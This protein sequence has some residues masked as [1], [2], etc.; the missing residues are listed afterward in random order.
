VTFRPLIGITVGPDRIRTGFVSVRSDY[1]KA[2][3]AAGGMPLLLAPMS[4]K[5][6]GPLLERLDGIV[7]SGGEDVDPEWYG[8]A[9]HPTVTEVTPERDHFEIALAREALSRDRPLLAICRGQQVLNVATG[10]TLIQD[11]PSIVSGA[12]DHDPKR[13]RWELAHHVRVLPGSRLRRILGEDE[14]AVNS[15]HHQVVQ[16]LGAGLVASAWSIGDELVEGVEAPDRRFVVGVQ[17]HPESLWDRRPS[18]QS[19]FE[20]LVSA[21]ADGRE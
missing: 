4:P 8:Q 3:E 16:D 11:V 5:D 1:V 21:S 17:W 6:T 12:V 2:V 20:A 10:G 9:L 7:L 14:V 15:F 18:F 13:E 19:L